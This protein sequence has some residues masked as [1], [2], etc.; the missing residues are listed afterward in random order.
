MRYRPFLQSK[1]DILFNAEF[2]CRG[3]RTLK[4]LWY[5]YV[6]SF[7][8][9]GGCHDARNSI[10]GG[11]IA[12]ESGP[13]EAADSAELPGARLGAG[14]SSVMNKSGRVDGSEKTG[15]GARSETVPE[16]AAARP[17]PIPAAKQRPQFPGPGSLEPASGA[18][19]GG[20]VPKMDSGVASFERVNTSAAAG[21]LEPNKRPAPLTNPAVALE[22]VVPGTPSGCQPGERFPLNR[23]NESAPDGKPGS[24]AAP[25]EANPRTKC[26]G[27]C[28]PLDGGYAEAVPP[29]SCARTR[30][31]CSA[32]PSSPD[33]PPRQSSPDTP[34]R[35]RAPEY[36]P[37]SRQA[38]PREV[39]SARAP[40]TSCSS[41][42]KSLAPPRDGIC[43]R[44]SK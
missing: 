29:V 13:G 5:R 27:T 2:T 34:P 21:S 24:G 9:Q 19:G 6:R 33:T 23:R 16:K 14:N 36:P 43:Q 20:S 37:T 31:L 26:R 17:A 11:R 39:D 28:N 3:G 18:R 30:P 40:G 1:E 12:S 38:P 35:K 15:S 32:Q 4:S 41:L 8:S 10:Q 42:V 44:P 25:P 22:S 7:W